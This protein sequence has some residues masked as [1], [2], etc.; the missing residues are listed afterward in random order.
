[1][2]FDEDENINTSQKIGLNKVSAQKSIFDTLPKKP[3]QE[4]FEKK[5]AAAQE[6]LGG[7]KQ[8]ASELA[9]QFKKIMDD[10]TLP[11]NKN[12]FSIEVEREVLSKMIQLAVDINNDPDEQE[13]MGSLSWI[14]FLFKLVLSHRDRINSLE[15]QIS[16][17][18][19]KLESN[20]ISSRN[21]KE[22]QSLDKNKKNE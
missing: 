15:Y 21:L 11:Q 16:L 10:K 5:V 8:K 13:G 14:T 3:N 20:N 1:M 9:V 7:Y 2:P 4:D 18:E 19:K 12:V 17:L 22:S 6:K